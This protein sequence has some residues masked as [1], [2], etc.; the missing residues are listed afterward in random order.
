MMGIINMSPVFF[1]LFL[2]ERLL[3]L[4]LQIIPRA[5]LAEGTAYTVLN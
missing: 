4:T 3:K 2:N 5:F 1:Q